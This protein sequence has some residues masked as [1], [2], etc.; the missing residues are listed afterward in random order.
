[1][2]KLTTVVHGFNVGIV[3]IDNL[4][5][6]DLERMRLAAEEQENIIGTVTGKG[7]LRPGTKYI[8]TADGPALIKDFIFSADDAALLEFTNQKMRVLVGDVVVTR[9]SVST[10]VTSG[11]FSSST[12]WTLA[13]T[14]GA[15]ATISGGYLNLTAQGRGSFAK[16]RQQVTVASGDQN[17]EHALEIVINRGPVAFM[18]GTSSGDDSYISRTELGEGYHSLAFTPT[19]NFWVEFQTDV[20]VLRRVDSITIAS[21]GD[22]EI[23]T[24]W[25]ES[26][27]S[28][29]RFDQSADV[30]YIAW[31]DEPYKIER[32]SNRSWSVVKYLANDGPF[33]IPN[34][35][36]I[37][38]KPTAL[39]GN[40]TLTSNVPFF[41]Q[42]HVGALF[43][44][45]HDGQYVTQYLSDDYQYTD[46]IKVTG[47]EYETD[48]LSDRDWRYD[49]EETW[50]GT[51]ELQRSYDD[52][53]FG[54]KKV[55][56]V[57]ANASNIKVED[58][59]DNAIYYYRFGFRGGY[60]SGTAKID[61]RYDGG[62]GY[63]ICRVTGYVSRTQVNVEVIRPFKNTTYT[64]I[65][66]EGE[67][68]DNGAWPTAVALAEG[69][70]F[71]GGEDSWWG[72]VSDAYESFDE[73][74]EGDAAP[75][76]RT[77][78]VGGVNDVQWMISA[79][80]LVIGSNGAEVVARSSSLDE[81][82][83][84]T[85]TTLKASSTIGSAPIS[86]VRIDGNIVFADRSAKA[87]F[88]M[89]INQSGDY[90]S[91]EITRLCSRLFGAG[92]K[93]IA[94]QRRPDTRIWVVLTSGQC[95]CIVYEPSQEV[96]AFIRIKTAGFYDSVAVLPGNGE[97]SVY[98]SV[99][100]ASDSRYIE[101]MADDAAAR[102][103]TLAYV[104]DSYVEGTNSPAS[105]TITGLSHLN[106]KS[107][108][109]WADGAPINETT[110]TGGRTWQSPRLFI[111]TGGQISLPFAVTNYVVGL[112]Y[113]GRYKSGRLAYGATQGTPMLKKQKVSDLGLILTD[114][115]RSGVLYGKDYD[116]IETMFPLRELV[117]GAASPD[118]NSD[119][120]MDEEPHV[121]QSG[122]TIDERVCVELSWPC[123]LLA[124]TYAVETNG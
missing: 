44:L 35:R 82:L 90:V 86:P 75:L 63:G 92:I 116:D 123:S 50:V 98:F 94:I 68:S 38:L 72:S 2:A 73:E 22:M 51:I 5:R 29:L 119:T 27:L 33:K 122:W 117:G 3:D 31:G 121:F 41:N 12:G 69:R 89:A 47:V 62:G 101:K 21:A 113:K 79:N 102:P 96:A 109:V 105:T 16:A 64:D 8:T 30:V 7:F 108:K 54:Y 111:V 23:V 56:D 80:R 55:V 17:K 114:Y 25:S 87:L 70:L 13:P 20:D 77:I 107:V 42:G 93:Q 103:G 88:E 91:N 37:R 99:K 100:R 60:T 9:P 19:G 59:A 18:C 32:R 106:G 24:P 85:N 52:P 112:P 53:T 67:W 58:K 120:V 61:I 95:V 124:L 45:D 48:S 43:R 4:T 83:T 81:P 118:V 76:S 97:D 39:Q 40:T 57:I 115:V 66:Q 84:A 11:T 49:V 110:A 6:I 28:H 14:E 36:K 74:I 34:T 1:M 26:D 10:A 65:W 15:T 46:P 71:W 78:A 104:M